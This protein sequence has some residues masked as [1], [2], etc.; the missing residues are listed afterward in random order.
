MRELLGLFQ[1]WL[2]QYE[3]HFTAVNQR[4]DEV[5][6]TNEKREFMGSTQSLHT[7]R[8][9]SSSKRASMLLEEARLK[10]ELSF[11]Q[12]EKE[13]EIELKKIKS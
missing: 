5:C 13:R 8:S 11:L 4:I 12:S 10:A 6:I 9:S 7:S 2:E 1:L 3:K